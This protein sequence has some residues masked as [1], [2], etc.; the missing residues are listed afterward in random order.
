M[1]LAVPLG[2]KTAQRRENAPPERAFGPY[3]VLSEG[4]TAG[5][6]VVVFNSLGNPPQRMNAWEMRGQLM[7][8]VP[9]WQV[10]SVRDQSRS[11]F[12]ADPPALKN[13]ADW[14]AARV[15][16]RPGPRVVTL[17]SSVG[18]FG[19]LL[20]ARLL[21]ADTCIA[22]SPQVAVGRSLT[23][24]CD[25][26]WN[27]FL[28]P[29]ADML[30]P[31]V[32][33][34]AGCVHH[35]LFPAYDLLDVWQ[36]SLLSP[37][38]AFFYA[39]LTEEHN[40]AAELKSQGVLGP[41]IADCIHR[42][43]EPSSVPAAP[44]V[45]FNFGGRSVK[46]LLRSIKEGAAAGR[47]FADWSREVQVE[48][49][50]DMLFFPY[51]CHARGD[52]LAQDEVAGLSDGQLLSMLRRFPSQ[53]LAEIVKARRSAHHER[54]DPSKGWLTTW[55]A[56][57]ADAGTLGTV[58]SSGWNSI[59]RWGV[60]SLGMVSELSLPAMLVPETHYRLRLSVRPPP[61]S[62]GVGLRVVLRVGPE[63]C[64][65]E[66]FSFSDR[67]DVVLAFKTPATA[68]ATVGVTASVERTVCPLLDHP[69]YSDLRACG[70]GLEAVSIG[71]R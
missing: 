15:A 71:V 41:F 25:H 37:E 13:L 63:I 29:D 50:Y 11:W 65:T 20:F 58:L 62:D 42:P 16:Q 53:K 18:A 12:N 55:R 7:S 31:V 49:P 9:D 3:E 34:A 30:H 48:P 38:Q 46:S 4:G 57:R 45:R 52:A 26:R 22:L 8:A 60:W 23:E 21:K 27:G 35:V 47:S 10:I 17:G 6:A 54:P 28:P 44:P 69:V 5:G 1:N 40:C 59:E 43:R 24:G 39:R 66:T 67:H 32:A 33:P 51:W 56:W 68:S 61:A 36:A 19:A 64:A 14:L 2:G 70:F